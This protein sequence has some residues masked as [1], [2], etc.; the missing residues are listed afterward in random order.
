[1]SRILACNEIKIVFDTLLRWVSSLCY[2]VVCFV[3]AFL[4][5][6]LN[7]NIK[8]YIRI[9]KSESTA[10][11]LKRTEKTIATITHKTLHR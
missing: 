1:M 4:F 10:A 8:I 3:L 7:A 2:Q 11:N 5:T 6:S 9:V